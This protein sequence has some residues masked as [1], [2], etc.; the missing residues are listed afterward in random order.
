M[1]SPLASQHQSRQFMDACWDRFAK[2]RNEFLEGIETVLI[3][4]DVS[5]EAGGA[6]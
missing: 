3:P 6:S 1:T 2:E 5:S 4:Q